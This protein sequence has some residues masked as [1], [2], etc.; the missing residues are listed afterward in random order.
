MKYYCIGI[1]G[2]GMAT[3]A[4]ILHDLGNEVSGYDDV[5]EWKFTQSGLEERHITIIDGQIP[6][7]L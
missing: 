6:V 7:R 4:N 2:A 3:L 1:K 5:K